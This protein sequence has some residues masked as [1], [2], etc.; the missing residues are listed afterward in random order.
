MWRRASPCP[1]LNLARG[2]PNPRNT[3]ALARSLVRS[4][5]RSLAL[6]LT[7]TLTKASLT[8]NWAR[9]I[10][11]W[12]GREQLPYMLLG[13]GG[14]KPKG[15]VVLVVAAERYMHDSVST[16]IA[17]TRIDDGGSVRRTCVGP[18]VVVAVPIL[19]LLHARL[20]YVLF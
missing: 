3:L 4:L 1:N 6:A 19:A 9:E 2:S 16:D 20:L 5:A 18:I 10:E 8:S 13:E 12:I 15:Q 17:S 11:K 14:R 7:L